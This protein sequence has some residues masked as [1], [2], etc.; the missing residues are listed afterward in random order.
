MSN[1]CETM[2]SSTGSGFCKENYRE[3]KMLN[4]STIYSTCPEPQWDEEK[5]DSTNA[6][7]PNAKGI[8]GN[9]ER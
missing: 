7:S 4:N 5:S 9:F 6:N 2:N 3:Q 1:S 8:K